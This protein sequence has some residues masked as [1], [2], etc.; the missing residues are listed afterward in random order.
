[1]GATGCGMT[2]LFSSGLGAKGTGFESVGST[3]GRI[4]GGACSGFSAGG[5]TIAGTP[6]LP[7]RGGR[8][9]I[10]LSDIAVTGAT[11]FIEGT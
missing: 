1:M 4:I 11:G 8:E 6:S 9:E 3:L 7:G 5:E 2:I 10:L